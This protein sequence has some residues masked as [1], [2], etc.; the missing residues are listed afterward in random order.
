MQMLVRWSFFHV[1]AGS[2][3]YCRA[4][5]TGGLITLRSEILS[6]SS[7]W[8]IECMAETWLGLL[9]FD[10]VYMRR[11]E[12]SWDGGLTIEWLDLD[13]VGKNTL[14]G[15]KGKCGCVEGQYSSHMKAFVLGDLTKNE[16]LILVFGPF[17]QICYLWSMPQ[18]RIH[19]VHVVDRKTGPNQCTAS[20]S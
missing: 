14:R 3:I 18:T 2:R 6:V 4:S 10:G 12:M 8:L 11:A 9:C 5:L 17:D 7:W 19:A 1:L 20:I 15:L 16:L 13:R